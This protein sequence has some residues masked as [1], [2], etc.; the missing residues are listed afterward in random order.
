MARKLAR[1]IILA[2]TAIA[3]FYFIMGLCA[4]FGISEVP[5]GFGTLNIT[6]GSTGPAR[7]GL[8]WGGIAVMLFMVDRLTLKQR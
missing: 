4:E 1:A 5:V 6:P 2:L 7:I 3:L 8:L